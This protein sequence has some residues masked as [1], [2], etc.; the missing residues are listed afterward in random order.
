MDLDSIYFQCVNNSILHIFI[1]QIVNTRDG[2]T[3]LFPDQ[4][5]TYL[6]QISWLVRYQQ[7]RFLSS[8]NFDIF[9]EKWTHI[10]FSD[11]WKSG[12]RA[13][14]IIWRDPIWPCLLY[15]VAEV[16]NPFSLAY[17]KSNIFIGGCQSSLKVVR[18]LQDKKQRT[19]AYKKVFPCI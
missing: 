16:L 4:I 1:N 5:L 2:H 19:F 7:S 3:F 10:R 6:R 17:F 8:R 13:A 18:V 14:N 9:W 15:T 12:S 11:K